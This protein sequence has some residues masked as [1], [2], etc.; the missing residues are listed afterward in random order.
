MEKWAVR[1]ES[2]R[3]LER[4]PMKR[5]KSLAGHWVRVGSDQVCPAAERMCDFLLV[6]SLLLLLVVVAVL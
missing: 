4:L 2:L 1:S 6:L 5:R 3:S